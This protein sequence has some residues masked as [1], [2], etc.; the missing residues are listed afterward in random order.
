MY[1]AMAGTDK[2]ILIEKGVTDINHI[3]EIGPDTEE[4]YIV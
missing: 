4:W 2:A 3:I 1:Y